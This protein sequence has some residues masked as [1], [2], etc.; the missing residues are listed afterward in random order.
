MTIL[1]VIAAA[2]TF[3]AYAWANRA[4]RDAEVIVHPELAA[5]FDAAVAYVV[6]RFLALVFVGLVVAYVA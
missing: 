3:L 5:R 1:V 6:S 4:A 2:L